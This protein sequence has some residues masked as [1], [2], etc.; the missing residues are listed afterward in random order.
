C[1]DEPKQ[2][3]GIGERLL[4]RFPHGRGL[5]RAADF[6]WSV[7]FPVTD[8]LVCVHYPA[9][10]AGLPVA[11]V[12]RPKVIYYGLET[13]TGK[14][15]VAIEAT[16]CRRLSAVALVPEDNRARVLRSRLGGRCS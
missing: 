9:L 13:V 15:N 6:A 4:S 14:M 16:L 2:R 5:G 3:Y 7:G 1:S 11:L 8:V 10:C 12:R